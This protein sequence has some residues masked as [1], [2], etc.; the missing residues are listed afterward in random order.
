M[1]DI[2]NRKSPAG[3]LRDT[4]QYNNPQ[5][6]P[7]ARLNTGPAAAMM[8]KSRGLADAVS[9]LTHIWKSVELNPSA[10]ATRACVASCGELLSAY[11]ATNR[12]VGRAAAD[13]VGNTAV[14]AGR[15][16]LIGVFQPAEESGVR[17]GFEV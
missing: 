12:S 14:L 8:A 13:Q 3:L 4:L 7:T 16:L 15:A 9:G 6:A 1:S 5:I 2:I 17:Y 10:Y 11:A